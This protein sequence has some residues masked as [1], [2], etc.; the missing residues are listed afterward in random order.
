MQG[1]FDIVLPRHQNV[2]WT[3]EGLVFKIEG[4]FYIKSISQVLAIGM[5]N[6]TKILHS[7]TKT[8]E[9]V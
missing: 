5:E 1:R 7:V 4:F 3:S 6:A 8:L 2:F 9:C